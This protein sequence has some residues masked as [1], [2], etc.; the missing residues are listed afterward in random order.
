MSVFVNHDGVSYA[1][2][3]LLIDMHG[4][5]GDLSGE[6]ILAVCIEAAEATGATVLF[7]YQHPFEGGGSSGVV[8][9]AESHCAFHSW[10]NEDNYIAFDVFVCGTCNPHLAVPVF[11]KAFNPKTYTVKLYR[12]GIKNVQ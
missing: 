8:I 10:P 11:L 1:G 4:C 6:G 7:S 2:N 5:S 9:L 3:H 12:R